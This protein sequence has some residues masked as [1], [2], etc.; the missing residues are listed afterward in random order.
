[1]ESG[2]KLHLYLWLEQPNIVLISNYADVA[3]TG[4]LSGA[5]DFTPS[6]RWTKGSKR[7]ALLEIPGY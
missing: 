1:M 6:Q 3:V 7:K 2:L 4:F 5:V